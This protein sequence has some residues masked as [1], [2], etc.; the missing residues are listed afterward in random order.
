M[1]WTVRCRCK[2]GALERLRKAEVYYTHGTQGQGYMGNFWV[3][4]RQNAY[5]AEPLLRF[6]RERK[7]RAKETVQE[8]LLRINLVASNLRGWPL[9][10]WYLVLG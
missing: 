7:S 8:W 5:R 10:A 6:L 2:E 1:G 4:R 9:V 3:V